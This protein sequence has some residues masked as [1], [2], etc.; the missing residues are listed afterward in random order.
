MSYNLKREVKLFM[1]FDRLGDTVR[2][3]P[4]LWAINRDRLEDVKNH[5]FDLVIM[6]KLIE[7][8]FPR[9]LNIDINLII[10]YILAHDLPEALTGDITKFEGVSDE[11]RD[12][13]T[14][15][16]MDYL[17]EN[18]G[19]ILNFRSLFDGFEKV[20]DLEAKIANL[21][22]AIHSSTTF[23]KYA[24]EGVIDLNDPNII[25]ELDY[26][27]KLAKENNWDIGDVFYNYHKKRLVI[28]DEECELY[29]ISRENADII[30]DIVHSLID[31]FYKQKLD[32]SLVKIGDDLPKNAGIYKRIQK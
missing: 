16:A 18:Y 7:R 17:V 25:P 32:G 9:E 6:L 22:D 11:E 12:R 2:S 23:L 8:Y 3:G 13:V 20:T 28:S 30:L 15:I 1:I 31:E 4:I 19:D 26:Y 10:E 21:L 29:N 14:N 24:C 27:I 5:I